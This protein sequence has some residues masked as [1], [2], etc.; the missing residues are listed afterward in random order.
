M[1]EPGRTLLDFEYGND[2]LV[3]R[4][5]WPGQGP[6][7]AYEFRTFTVSVAEVPQLIAILLARVDQNLR[8]DILRDEVRKDRGVRIQR[9]ESM[10]QRLD[11]D[12]PLTAS[13]LAMGDGD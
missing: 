7:D 9:A 5:T 11:P 6:D 1:P 3:A 12:N 8:A 4:Y 2:L 10:G 13:I